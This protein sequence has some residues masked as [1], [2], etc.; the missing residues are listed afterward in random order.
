MTPKFV[1]RIVLFM[2]IMALS[3]QALPCG[4]GQVVTE[5]MRAWARQTVSQESD[6]QTPAAPNTVG[7]LYFQNTSGNPDIDPLSKGMALM[8][9][10]DL[11]KIKTLQVVERIRVQALMDEM[12]LA[13]TGLTAPGTEPR[14]GVLLRAS[15]LVGG[16]LTSGPDFELGTDARTLKV[17]TAQLVDRIVKEGSLDQLLALEKELVFG[18]VEALQLQLDEAETEALRVPLSTNILALLHLFKGIDSSDR[19][20]Y[21][22]A[23]RNYEKALA[24]DPKLNLAGNALA[25][26]EAL[27]LAQRNA[28]IRSLMQSI[29]SR[30]SHTDNPFSESEHRWETYEPTG[31]NNHGSNH[32]GVKSCTISLE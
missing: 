10:T 12:A 29:R 16:E 15:Y 19:G 11:A 25:E 22:N 4:A 21:Q 27:G 18:I 28:A 30:T 2:F 13:D 31:R 6:F 14:M 32:L 9:I 20:N 24:L 17:P 8:L 26:L 23:A 5:D 1:K 3:L 7:V